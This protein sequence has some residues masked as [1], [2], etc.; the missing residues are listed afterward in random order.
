MDSS[1]AQIPAFLA[2]HQNVKEGGSLTDDLLRLEPNPPSLIFKGATFFVLGFFI[3]GIRGLPFGFLRALGPGNIE[4]CESEGLLSQHHSL[5]P[6]QI[7]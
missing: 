1:H 5:T 3:S 6:C 4:A 2:C 7:F